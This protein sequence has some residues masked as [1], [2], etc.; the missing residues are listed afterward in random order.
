MVFVNYKEDQIDSWDLSVDVMAQ[1]KSTFDSGSVCHGMLSA[2]SVLR[3]IDLMYQKHN[4]RRLYEDIRG[5]Y[6]SWDQTY[7]ERDVVPACAAIFLHNLPATCFKDKKI[8]RETAP[9]AFLLRLS[10]S[11]QEWD[12]PSKDN[13]DGYPA[14]EFD[15]CVENDSLVLSVNL[16]EKHKEKIRN[17]IDSSLEAED[18]LIR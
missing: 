10:D 17:E 13:P 2:I 14:S 16:P 9:L 5:D 18:I 15:I 6:S 7:F 1:F 12:R 8:S 3:T 4:P 11:L